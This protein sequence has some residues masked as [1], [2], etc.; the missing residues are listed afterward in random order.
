MTPWFHRPLKSFL[1]DNIIFFLEHMP[2]MRHNILEEAVEKTGAYKSSKATKNEKK[3]KQK[4]KKEK[5]KK[6]VQG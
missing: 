4:M 2:S 3:R 1:W 6:T 5:R